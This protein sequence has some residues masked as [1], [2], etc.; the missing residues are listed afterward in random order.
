MGSVDLL[1]GTVYYA[2]NKKMW[3][4][5][6]IS[7][8]GLPVG[9]GE[10]CISSSSF[11]TRHL[12]GEVNCVI[13]QNLTKLVNTPL[14]CCKSP[15]IFSCRPLWGPFRKGLLELGDQSAPDLVG[16]HAVPLAVKQFFQVCDRSMQL[17]RKTIEIRV[18]SKFESTFWDFATPL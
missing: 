1:R 15:V 13:V 11:D 18:V 8:G 12:S 4:L 7:P 6:G 10:D 17:E 16:R 5:R 3:Q 14:S 2:K 9:R